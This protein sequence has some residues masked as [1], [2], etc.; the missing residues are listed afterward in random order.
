[1]SGLLT[2]CSSS[3]HSL[4][5]KECNYL[6]FLMKGSLLGNHCL[7]RHAM[8]SPRTSVATQ[9]QKVPMVS[10]KVLHHCL[11]LAY[12]MQEMRILCAL[13][14]TLFVFPLKKLSLLGSGKFETNLKRVVS[15]V[16]NG[17]PCHDHLMNV[18]T[19]S[20]LKVYKIKFFSVC[21]N[22]S[23]TTLCFFLHPISDFCLL[24]MR[25]IT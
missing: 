22:I 13:S 12:D 5:V 23:A 25:N 6:H 16:I 9:N 24:L 11:L 14:L 18:L 21:Q 19:M 20:N 4:E 7:V 10:I 8:L 1:M 2:K 3:E 15:E 17:V